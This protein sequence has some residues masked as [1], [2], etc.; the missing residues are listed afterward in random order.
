MFCFTFYFAR[1]R[2]KD[3]CGVWL[4]THI[5]LNHNK[6][7]KC[8]KEDNPRYGS[9]KSDFWRSSW[10]AE[11]STK[12][13]SNSDPKLKNQL[14]IKVNR[15]STNQHSWDLALWPYPGRGTRPKPRLRD[16]IEFVGG[17]FAP[18]IFVHS[19]L[20]ILPLNT[21]ISEERASGRLRRL[22]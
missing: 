8:T 9:V 22:C 12:I 19:P 20:S 15:E 5:D 4:D 7:S 14:E 10:L 16:K 2:A 13:M 6:R 18:P 3:R 17:A 21:G 1:G 11:E